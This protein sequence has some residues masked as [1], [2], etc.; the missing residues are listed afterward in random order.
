MMKEIYQIYFDKIQ[1]QLEVVD[2]LNVLKKCITVLWDEMLN[3]KRSY[4]IHTTHYKLE[5][6]FGKEK[7]DQ[8]EVDDWIKLL[9]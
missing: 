9:Y 8:F 4:D 3:Q 1:N 7:A 6:T 2:H 5:N